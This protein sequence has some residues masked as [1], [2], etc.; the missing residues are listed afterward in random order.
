MKLG[1]IFL[2]AALSANSWAYMGDCRLQQ[3]QW[4]MDKNDERLAAVLEQ[5]Y[6]ELEAN[7]AKITAE[8]ER[9]AKLPLPRIGM[10]Q[11]QAEASRWGA[12]DSINS[13]MDASGVREQWVYGNNYLYFKN[14]R[15]TSIQTSR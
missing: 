15:L 5:C 12:P 3:Y 10:T 1:W 8:Q 7:N 6:K 9:V 11:K 2:T 4:E 14:G 13:T